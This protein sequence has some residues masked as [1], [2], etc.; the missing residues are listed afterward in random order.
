[1]KAK[2]YVENEG[3]MKKMKQLRCVAENFKKQKNK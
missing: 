2:L 1:M 3:I